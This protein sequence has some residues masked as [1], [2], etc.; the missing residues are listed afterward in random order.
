MGKTT[1]VG[2]FSREFDNFLSINLEKREARQLFETTD[3]V[4]Q[5]L[6]LL[7]LYCNIK[8]REGRTLLFLDEVQASPQ[9]VALL[10]SFIEFFRSYR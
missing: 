2:Q 1:I 4:K 6:P 5:L 3:D 9:A 8:Q 7:F 10:C